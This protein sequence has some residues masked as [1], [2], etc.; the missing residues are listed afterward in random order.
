[1]QLQEGKGL[2]KENV[3]NKNKKI[4]FFYKGK[5]KNWDGKLDKDIREKIENKFYNEMKELGY[6]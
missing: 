5:I 6:L 2:F 3:E 4:K 1:M